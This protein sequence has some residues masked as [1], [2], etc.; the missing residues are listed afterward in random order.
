MKTL[1]LIIIFALQLNI[2][3]AGEVQVVDVQQFKQ[4]L[5]SNQNDKVL[6]FFTSWCRA[7]M[8]TIPTITAN[9]IIF[10]S[11]DRKSEAIENIAKDMKYD[12]YH[13]LPSENFE[14]ILELS[15]MLNIQIARIN[16]DRSTSISYPYIAFLDGNNKVLIEKINKNDLHQYLK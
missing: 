8:K 3:Y 1:I 9:N 12:V 13:I 7:C 4:V 10:I 16:E 5:D 6:F 14:N 2:V 11:L 15:D